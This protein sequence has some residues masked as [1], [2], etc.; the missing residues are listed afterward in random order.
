MELHNSIL[1]KESF[2][3]FDT[4]DGLQ[5]TE[6]TE[7]GKYQAEDGEILCSGPRGG[8]SFYPDRIQ[9]DARVPEI[10]MAALIVNGEPQAPKDTGAFKGVYTRSKVL[11]CPL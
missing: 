9:E 2:N 6:F 10:Q 11:L 5:I 7:H 1:I 3:V 4:D 8:I